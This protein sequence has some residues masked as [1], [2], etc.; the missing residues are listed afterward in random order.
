MCRRN[1]DCDCGNGCV[2]KGRRRTESNSS[3]RRLEDIDR[4]KLLRDT[5]IELD[6]GDIFEADYACMFAMDIARNENQSLRRIMSQDW[7]TKNKMMADAVTEH[8]QVIQRRCFV[9]AKKA[10]S[11]LGEIREKYPEI[12]LNSMP[13][14]DE[15]VNEA[16]SY[17]KMI[18]D[19]KQCIAYSELAS[20]YTRNSIVWA[21][22]MS[23]STQAEQ[24]KACG[25]L[26][27]MP[28]ALSCQAPLRQNKT[29][30]VACWSTPSMLASGR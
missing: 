25:M 29:K 12:K 21:W 24:D 14:K 5:P 27:N 2:S 11:N 6:N 15:I 7:S 17:Y 1:C 20:R 28:H 9:E 22:V 4:D 26:T 30:H 3:R 8:L 19:M 13:D 18:L 16:H 10:I 23:S